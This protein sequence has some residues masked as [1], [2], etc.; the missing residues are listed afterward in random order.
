M[1][2]RYKLLKDWKSKR[3]GGKIIT[4]GTFVIITRE[5]ELKELIDGE[6]IVAPKAKKEKK[7]KV[8]KEDKKKVEKENIEETN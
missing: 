5:N 7:K 2:K 4:A 1:E 3:H 6:H 8:E